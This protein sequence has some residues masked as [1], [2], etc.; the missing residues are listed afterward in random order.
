[1]SHRTPDF[2]IVRSCISTATKWGI[3]NL[4]TTKQ[5]FTTSAWLPPATAPAE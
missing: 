2:A 5:L 1:M 4:D 3:T